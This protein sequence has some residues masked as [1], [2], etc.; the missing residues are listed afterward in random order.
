[1]N[2]A[3]RPDAAPMMIRGSSAAPV[4]IGRSED[5]LPH[6]PKERGAT[7]NHNRY[8]N[9]PDNP[10]DGLHDET[11]RWE[12]PLCAWQKVRFWLPFWGPKPTEPGC[13]APLASMHIL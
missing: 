6:Y 11:P 4:V 10:P 13:F 5:Q 2:C 7:A 12:A 9:P 1:M 3:D 8:R